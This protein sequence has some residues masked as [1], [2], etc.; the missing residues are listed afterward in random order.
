MARHN[1]KQKHYTYEA[2]SDLTWT[3]IMKMIIFI[4]DNCIYFSYWFYQ[5]IK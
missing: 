1:G 4:K 2:N 5:E 3:E